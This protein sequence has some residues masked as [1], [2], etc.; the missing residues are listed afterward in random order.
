[1]LTKQNADL[2]IITTWK[3]K[4]NQNYKWLNFS[5]NIFEF[6]KTVIVKSLAKS[7][8]NKAKH[9]ISFLLTQAYFM[10]IIET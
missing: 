2:H 1:M 10:S 5:P 3:E 7:K 9:E 4:F 6:S 8:K